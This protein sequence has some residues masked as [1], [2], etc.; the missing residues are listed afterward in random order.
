MSVDGDIALVGAPG[1]GSGVVYVFERSD[2]TWT[3]VGSFSSQNGRNGDRFGASIDFEGNRAVVGAEGRT[4]KLIESGAAYIFEHDGNGN[5]TQEKRLESSSPVDQGLF[6]ASVAL[7]GD[8]ALVGAHGEMA[9]GNAQGG[10]A[11]VFAKNGTNWPEQARLTSAD[12]EAG[13]NFGASVALSGNIAGIG[14]PS[15]SSASGDATGAAYIFESVNGT[16]MQQTKLTSS[17]A[18]PNDRFGSAV[19]LRG[20][21]AVLGASGDNASQGAFYAFP[22]P[23]AAPEIILVAPAT[24][25]DGVYPNT[26]LVITFDE[27]VFKRNGV[28]QIKDS[29]GYL[30]ETIQASDERVVVDGNR[31][32]IYPRTLLEYGKTYEVVISSR[33][34]RNEQNLY[35]TGLGTPAFTPTF[36]P[37]PPPTV[38]LG[39]GGG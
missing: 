6:G 18:D 9:N 1:K 22:V 17:D 11:Y 4:V 37:Q 24:G 25:S 5:W 13:D 19:A 20:T 28:I 29:D 16:W 26:D 27:P 14:A 31:V 35:F 39:G 2:T 36:T 15:K 23:E 32:T 12:A 30:V 7:E 3:Q 8:T 34:F 33:A 38:P 10:A 21:R